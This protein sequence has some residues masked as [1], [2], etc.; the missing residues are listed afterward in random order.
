MGV[1]KLWDLL[2]ATALPV[3][4][5]SLF[6]KVCCID[7]SFWII[8]CLASDS[9][10]RHGGDVIAVFFLR[11]CYLLDKGIRPVFVFDG[12][13]PFAKMKTIIKRKMIANKYATNHKLFAF[14]LLA[15]QLKSDHKYMNVSC[16]E[17]PMPLTNEV[18]PAEEV[19][20]SSDIDQY[21]HSG[22]VDLFELFPEDFL[23]KTDEEEFDRELKML[24]ECDFLTSKE[25]YELMNAVR[26]RI[27]Q[28][29]RDESLKLK[30]KIDEYS[31]HQIQSYM[32]DMKINNEIE[33]LK[34]ELYQ[35]YPAA[36]QRVESMNFRNALKDEICDYN[37]YFLPNF[38]NNFIALNSDNGYDNN[39]ELKTEEYIKE[40]LM[41]P[42]KEEIDDSV[43]ATD[44][45]IFG[46]EFM[47]GMNKVDEIR[48]LEQEQISVNDNNNNSNNNDVD[49]HYD[50]NDDASV[51]K[52]RN[53]ELKGG[54]DIVEDSTPRT[55]G[56]D[57]FL[58]LYKDYFS[59]KREEDIKSQ[60]KLNS[61]EKSGNKQKPVDDGESDPKANGDDDDDQSPSDNEDKVFIAKKP[62]TI[63]Q[64]E[65]TDK[66]KLSQ[67][68][69]YYDDTQQL[70]ELFGV[71]YLIAP[72]EAE[73]QCA[74]MNA[75][76]DCYAVISDDSDAFVFGAKCLL[77]NFYNDNVFELYTSE[78]IQK[79]LGI[80]REQLALIAVICG[81]DFTN[82][83][84][85]I[86]VVNALEVIKAYPKFEDLYEFKH[87]ATSDCNVETA[88]SDECPLRSE[89]KK[90]H[91]NYRVHW[92]FSSD[93][94]NRE[95]Y[96]LF[97]NPSTTDEY[98]LSWKKPELQ[99]LAEFMLKKAS[100]PPEE[101]KHCIDMLYLRRSQQFIMEDVVP[102]IASKPY[103][104][105]AL[106]N[107]RKSLKMNLSAFR[108]VLLNIN[109][110]SKFN[111][112]TKLLIDRS[113]TLSKIRS[114]RMNYYR[115]TLYNIGKDVEKTPFSSNEFEHSPKIP[116]VCPYCNNNEAYFMSI[117]TRSADEPMTQFFVCTSCTKRWKE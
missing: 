7:A 4:V 72:S 91:I 108:K 3:R 61:S 28:K 112:N 82:G 9:I 86:G 95:A 11:I 48:T 68:K 114:K 57:F 41:K 53:D 113:H 31:N 27:I 50:D 14:K 56:N 8:H 116:A 78:R 70:L 107:Y 83:V 74:Y 84:R 30:G 76:G 63:I 25:K 94:P 117:Q 71:P 16:V 75:K 49:D 73:S 85:G 44:D 87:W 66:I 103:H 43:F 79:L 99:A 98:S 81:C 92:T 29:D 36:E 96:E 42:H 52:G 26:D 102:D 54:T 89:Y 88:M 18:V 20:N 38:E 1:H 64:P 22:E 21:Q 110:R 67:N 10:N 35:R 109:S 60:N 97:L 69:M 51:N 6:G 24:Q 39:N 105:K 101:V 34:N 90:A 45:Q 32:R 23:N 65:Q 62:D 77:K 12:K 106:A 15:T 55:M 115:A 58:S 19:D 40:K 37:Q 33:Q 100:I 93:F 13:S 104:K 59:R 111:I 47:S 80:R 46:E 2:T 17:D 5:E